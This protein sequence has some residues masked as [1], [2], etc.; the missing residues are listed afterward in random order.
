MAND[1]YKAAVYEAKHQLLHLTDGPITGFVVV[2]R[3]VELARSE[4]P[5]RG[6]NDPIANALFE[7]LDELG[8][9]TPDGLDPGV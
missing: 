4:G 6:A 9:L 5:W 2:A 3:A 7:V 1:S 8:M